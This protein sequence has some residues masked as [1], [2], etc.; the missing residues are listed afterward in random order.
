[1]IDKSTYLEPFHYGEGIEFVI[2]T[3]RVSSISTHSGV[4]P[5]GPWRP[6]PRSTRVLTQAEKPTR[7]FHDRPVVRSPV[8]EAADPAL[9]EDLLRLLSQ[10]LHHFHRLSRCVRPRPLAMLI[11]RNQNLISPSFTLS[12]LHSVR[13]GAG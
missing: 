5:E 12:S 10:I 8:D 2:V 4:L 1:M 3:G 7:L 11:V 9:V 13:N 6:E